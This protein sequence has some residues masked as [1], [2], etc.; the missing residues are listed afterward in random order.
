MYLCLIYVQ[1]FG[2]KHVQPPARCFIK[3]QK[4][5]STFAD[6]LQCKILAMF[7]SYLIFTQY[8]LEQEMIVFKHCTMI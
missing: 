3:K 8:K 7:T 6:D 1:S 4:I 2:G 5:F